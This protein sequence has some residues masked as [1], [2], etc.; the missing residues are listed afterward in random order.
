MSY[1]ERPLREYLED[2]ASGKPTPGGGSVSALSAALGVTMAQM[3]A[4]FTVGRDKFRDVEKQV[5]EL[6]GTLGEVRA[7]L[8]EL[9]EKDMQVY[10]Q[11]S[12]AYSLPRES[13]EEKAKRTEAVQQALAGALAVP[14]EVMQTTARALEATHRLADIGNP[15][16]IS[17]VGVAAELLFGA[18][19]GARLNVDVNLAYLSNEELLKRSRNEAEALEARSVRLHDEIVE[20]VRN[21][22]SRS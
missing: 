11:V 17:D 16:L 6:L 5:K 2:A 21:K 4:N 14:L 19:K 7:G 1:L 15:N 18:L 12:S 8:L 10:G 3:T 22:L 9:M 13:A 20:I